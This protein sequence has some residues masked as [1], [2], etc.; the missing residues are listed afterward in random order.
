MKSLTLTTSKTPRSLRRC[1]YKLRK[2]PEGEASRSS[3]HKENVVRNHFLQALSYHIMSLSALRRI[4]C[5]IMPSACGCKPGAEA[6]FCSPVLRNYSKRGVK[7][8][9]ALRMF[10]TGP[11]PDQVK[12]P[13][14]QLT[15]KE[16]AK[17]MW[18][19]YGKLAIVTY[20]GVYG[21]TLGMMYFALDTGV[22][23]AATFGFD[24]AAAIVK[25]TF[26][27]LYKSWWFV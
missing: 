14:Q 10:S 4:T 11:T 24:H 20:I 7:Q 19:N 18:K 21:S 8:T 22:F 27:P 15:F 13:E 1:R 16:K 3:H 9:T 12:E 17:N 26:S 25:V 6:L 5:T 23:N 2:Y